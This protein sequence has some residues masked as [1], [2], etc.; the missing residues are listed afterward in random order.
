MTHDA[1]PPVAPRGG[2][3]VPQAN[4]SEQ[5]STSPTLPLRVGLRVAQRHLRSR[6]AGYLATQPLHRYWLE[7]VAVEGGEHPDIRIDVMIVDLPPG[8]HSPN[9]HPVR[10]DT[11]SWPMVIVVDDV[12]Y[13]ILSELLLAG[14]PRGVVLSDGPVREVSDAIDV[15]VHGGCWLSPA[16]LALLHRATPRGANR[17]GAPNEKLTRRERDVLRLVARGLSNTEVGKHLHVAT[18]TV[19][20]HVR[21][22]LRKTSC[23]NRHQLIALVHGGRWSSPNIQQ[24]DRQSSALGMRC[25]QESSSYCQAV[26]GVEDVAVLARPPL[27]P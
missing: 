8:Q 22:L 26:R 18:T 4:D 25:A 17:R 5:K 14:Q 9:G 12:S 2:N 24:P 10:E 23:S 15:A 6:V 20:T 3:I 19:K 21:A 11:R 13:D 1:C 27:L 16:V 7:L